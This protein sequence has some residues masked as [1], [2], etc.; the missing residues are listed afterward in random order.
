MVDWEII[1]KILVIEKY[2]IY[3]KS[4]L[5]TY[6]DKYISSSKDVLIDNRLRMYIVFFPFSI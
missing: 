5:T 4:K 1:I 6:L 2:D 3:K